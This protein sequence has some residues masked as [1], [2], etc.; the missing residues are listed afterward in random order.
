M[1]IKLAL[2]LIDDAGEL[3]PLGDQ[4]VNDMIAGHAAALCQ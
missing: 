3:G 2:Q 4:T 1:L